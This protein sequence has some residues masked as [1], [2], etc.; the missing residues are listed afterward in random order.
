MIPKWVAELSDPR[1]DKLIEDGS[2]MVYSDD[3]NFTEN[4]PPPTSPGG[5]TPE[6]RYG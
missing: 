6:Q 2:L 4:S 3:E 5:V 1:I